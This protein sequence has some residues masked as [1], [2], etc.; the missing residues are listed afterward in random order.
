MVRWWGY[1]QLLP[2]PAPSS[3]N[4]LSSLLLLLTRL[5]PGYGLAA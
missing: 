5:H 4:G 1:L 3:K 2:R